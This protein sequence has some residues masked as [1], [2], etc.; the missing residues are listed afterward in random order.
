MAGSG[1][2]LVTAKLRG[3]EVVGYDRDPLAVLLSRSWVTTLRPDAF[4]AKAKDVLS[5]A[6]SRAVRLKNKD[7]Y[8][9]GADDETRK[10]VRYWFDVQNRVQLTALAQT[11]SRLRDASLRNF[12][13]CAFSRLI[14]TK[15]V[16]VS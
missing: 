15:S 7:A 9:H 8:P 6:R 10:F 16:G 14:I 3:H 13:W 12:M 1:T 2:T 11:I 4:R 5:R